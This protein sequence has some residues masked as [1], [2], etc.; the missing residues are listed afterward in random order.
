[1]TLESGEVRATF[2]LAHQKHEF[3]LVFAGNVGNGED[4]AGSVVGC[5]NR[6]HD[7]RNCRGSC[8]KP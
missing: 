6:N 4:V 1:M 7:Q 5:G 8:E 3:S 2:I